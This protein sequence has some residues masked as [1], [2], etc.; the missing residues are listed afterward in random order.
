[1][2]GRTHLAEEGSAH[3]RRLLMAVEGSHPGLHRHGHRL[4]VQTVS[5]RF[6]GHDVFWHFFMLRSVWARSL[7]LAM[8]LTT[9]V[10]RSKNLCLGHVAHLK[11]RSLRDSLSQI[12][13]HPDALVLSES[14]PF[15]REGMRPHPSA[16]CKHRVSIHHEQVKPQGSGSHKGW[17]SGPLPSIVTDA[18]GGELCLQQPFPEDLDD[19]YASRDNI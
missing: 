15:P 11:E 8:G 3:Q 16:I 5:T 14:A 17:E 1:V 4:A 6:R 13:P 2:L 19:L 18:T 10:S 12:A 7:S 9:L